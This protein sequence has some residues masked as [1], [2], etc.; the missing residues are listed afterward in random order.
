LVFIVLAYLRLKQTIE[1]EGGTGTTGAS[2]EIGII[3][4]AE[5]GLILK[6]LN[7]YG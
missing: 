5:T 4:A 6:D 2:L 1:E 3:D 7:G